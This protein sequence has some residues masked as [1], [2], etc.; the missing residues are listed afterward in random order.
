M[1]KKPLCVA[2]LWHM[3]QPDYGNTQTGE[4]YLP[5]TRFHAIKDYYDMGVLIRNQPDLHVTI[6][7]VPGLMDQLRAYGMGAAK[8]TYLK[9][10]QREAADLEPH[11]KAF[12]LQ[13]FFQL[14]WERMLLPYPRYRELLQKRGS[15]DAQGSCAE[16]LRRYTRQDYLDLQ[17][18]FN[19]SWCGHELRK[20]PE[21]A[22]LIQKGRNFAEEDK[23]FLLDLQTSFIRHILT[24]YG[25][26]MHESGIEISVS[27]YYHSIVPLLCDNRV[28]RE[29]VPEIPLPANPF[30]FPGDARD[31]I[32]RAQQRYVEEFGQPPRGMWPSEGSI[33]DSTALLAREAGLTWLASDDAVL[34]HSL[35]KAGS[36][37]HHLTD[38]QKYS[39]YRWGDGD[40]GPCFFFRDHGLSDLIGFTYSRWKAT[41]AVADFVQ[42][43]HTIHKNLPDD[44]RHYVVP[45]ILDGENAWEHYPANGVEFLS[46]LYRTVVAD[47]VLR[48]V[49]F[50]EFLELEPHRESLPSIV[51]GSWINRNLATW[52][53]HPEK[54]RAWDFLTAARSFLGSRAAAG[55][56]PT[57]FQEAYREMLIAE[58]SDWFWW[59][60]DDHQS[61]NAAEFDSL[62][63]SHVKNIYRFLSEPYPLDLDVPIKKSHPRT[64]HRNPVHTMSPRIDGQVTDYFEWLD[65]GYAESIGGSG[66]MHRAVKYVEKI[67]FGY[68]A[69]RFYL[70]LDPSA[71]LREGLPPDASLQLHFLGPRPCQLRV[72]RDKK[73]LWRC[74]WQASSPKRKP[75]DFATGKI[76]ELGIPLESLGVLNPDEMRFFISILHKDQELERF[77][78]NGFLSVPIDPWGLDH[79]EWIV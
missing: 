18:W 38:V 17:V 64:Q 61:E 5:W 6:N 37:S 7:V 35:A 76:F 13:C 45:V 63:R 39:V 74:S 68:D 33:S 19:L 48:T 34:F 4:I 2:I 62:F 78:P 47:S 51:A 60:G 66:S 72:E 25:Q 44:D 52:I 59:Y 50:S 32:R 70:R 65:A 58:G 43:L 53:G 14:P 22:A 49:T 41:D 29:A 28:A 73:H 24:L 21:I 15:P 12:L 3:H 57:K 56:D 31:Q 8:E 11:E 75:P 46:G 23:K 10:T 20:T 16:G 77:P 55:T 42:K 54:N 26:L 40:R 1:S 9:L 67:Y 79:E 36:A 71:E 30:A 27:P 69:N